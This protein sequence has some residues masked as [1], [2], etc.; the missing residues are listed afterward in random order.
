MESAG[1]VEERLGVF[2]RWSAQGRGVAR[3]SYGIQKLGGRLTVGL[4]SGLVVGDDVSSK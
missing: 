1:V 2:D 4:F 3:L